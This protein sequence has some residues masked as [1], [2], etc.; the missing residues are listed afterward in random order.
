MLQ[1]LRLRTG[2]LRSQPHH[3]RMA[4]GIHA[5]H[6]A[7]K[8]LQ[9]NDAATVTSGKNGFLSPRDIC[10]QGN[11]LTAFHEAGTR[12]RRVRTANS[13]QARNDHLA[14]AD[15][16]YGLCRTSA[17][18]FLVGTDVGMLVSRRLVEKWIVLRLAGWV[19]ER[20]HSGRR[21][22]VGAYEDFVAALDFRKRFRTRR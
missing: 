1:W 10:E 16:A 8:L 5:K 6:G 7:R 4:L 13:C 22:N 19:S 18:N 14:E 20:R 12:C 15:G 3:R 17:S 21:K 2:P 9:Y 11:S